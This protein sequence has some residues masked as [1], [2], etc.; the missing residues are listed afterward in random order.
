MDWI[1]G[2][3][4]QSCDTACASKG[5]TCIENMWPTSLASAKAAFGA[6]ASCSSWYASSNNYDPVQYHSY[7]CYYR[8]SPPTVATCSATPGSSRSRFCPCGNTGPRPTTWQ[9]GA[10]G[11]DCNKVCSAGG[12][13]NGAAFADIISSP[14]FTNNVQGP[15]NCTYVWPGVSSDNVNPYKDSTGHCYW[16][17]GAGTCGSSTGAAARF[18]PCWHRSPTSAPTA[19][20]HDQCPSGY[21]SGS[22]SCTCPAG[23][24]CCQKSLSSGCD[25]GC[26][27]SVCDS[28]GFTWVPL[29][30]GSCPYVCQIPAPTVAPTTSPYMPSTPSATPTTSAPTTSPTWTNWIQA[31]Q[32]QSCTQ[33]CVSTGST[34]VDNMWPTSLA[35][36]QAV[37]GAVA[38]SCSS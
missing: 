20:H 32:G 17:G 21:T 6:L 26:A 8:S 27:R 29:N 1:K 33:A 2:P 5:S 18:C 14:A 3:Q 15:A 31:T 37:L 25:E 38:S 28:A 36:A 23:G 30:Y 34:C 12:G 35:N 9:L 13:C 4:G 19:H 10:L 11:D 7:Y 16:G 22:G 24:G